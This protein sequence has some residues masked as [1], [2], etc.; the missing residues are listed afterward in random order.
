MVGGIPDPEASREHLQAWK[1]RIDQ[2]AADTQAMSDRFEGLKVTASDPDGNAMVTL[3]SSGNLID[4]VL[5]ERTRRIDTEVTSRA[6]LQAVQAAKAQV[7]ERSAE[8][9][10]ET[11]G[12]DSPAGRAIAERVRGRLMPD[13]EGH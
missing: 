5:S 12:A 6:I 2:L 7:A 8:I 4:I 10:S 3:D 1:G 9:V 13:G 11:L